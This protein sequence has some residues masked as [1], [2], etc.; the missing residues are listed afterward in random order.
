[1]LERPQAIIF[2]LDGTII[3]SRDDV[4]Y[5]CNHALTT[6]GKPARDVEEIRTMVGDGAKTLLARAFDLP[7]DAP[8]LADALENFHR[9]YRSHPIDHTT[10]YPGVRE[11]LSSLRI[12]VALA[13]NKTQATAETV[14]DALH[15]RDA[16]SFI[17]GGGNGPLKPDPHAIHACLK[18]L[19]VRASETWMVGDGPQDVGAGRAAGC[20]TVGVLSGFHTDRLIQAA[21]DRLFPDMQTLASFYATLNR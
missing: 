12:P 10:V 2:D 21:P 19:G 3:D 18:A 17:I 11:W 8:E 4:A 6:L 1:M 15:L 16:F 9:Y 20:F 7:A 13:T 5:A 14:I